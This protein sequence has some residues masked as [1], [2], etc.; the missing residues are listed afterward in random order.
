MFKKR[1]ENPELD[2]EQLCDLNNFFNRLP[3]E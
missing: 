2:R 1:P 3:T